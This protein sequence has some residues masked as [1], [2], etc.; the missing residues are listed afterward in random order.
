MQFYPEYFYDAIT[1]GVMG[2]KEE[3]SAFDGP[4]A[5]LFF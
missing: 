3:V 4:M 2:Q 1:I 5:V